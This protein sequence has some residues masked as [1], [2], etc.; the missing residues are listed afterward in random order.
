MILYGYWR[1]SA[2]YR[3]RIALNLKG[4]EYEQKS[5]HL[6]KNGGKQF[7]D[8]Y[9]A[10]NPA[11]LVPTL[12]DGDLT[13]N[14]SMAILDYIEQK[15][16]E[17][18]LLP[19]ANA[20]RA[21]VLALAND[22]ACDIHPLNNLRVL[23]YLSDHFNAGEQQKEEWYHQW[24][25][26]GFRGLETHARQYGSTGKFLFEDTLTLADAVLIPQ[27]YN[28]LRY[29]FDMKSYPLLYSI[30]ENCNTL[31]AFNDARP[32]NQPDVI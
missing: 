1:S 10:I 20:K 8:E 30:W 11:Q 28:A 3:V 26:K 5:V 2:A 24:L 31:Q 21:Q 6:L 16:S 4:I 23:K 25:K 22:V 32:E 27:I 15:Y 17:P 19:L 7:S 13:L 29:R 14:Q 12:V 18:A 9:T